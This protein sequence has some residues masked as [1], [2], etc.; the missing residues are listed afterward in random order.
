MLSK[1]VTLTQK[2]KKRRQASSQ[3]S[4]ATSHAAWFFS[5]LDTC[6]LLPHSRV[7]GRLTMP[8]YYVFMW[9]LC[10]KEED[11]KTERPAILCVCTK[12]IYVCT[13]DRR[14]RNLREYLLKQILSGSTLI[15]FLLPDWLRT[16][17]SLPCNSDSGNRKKE[18]EDDFLRWR[19]SIS[20][21]SLRD[22][23]LW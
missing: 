13:S 5:G 21:C 17:Y 12:H 22:Q 8:K 7:W 3:R 16:R 2:L 10:C 6:P 4:R 18:V 1:K 20:F 14:L 23:C 15:R 9:R 19:F 11:C